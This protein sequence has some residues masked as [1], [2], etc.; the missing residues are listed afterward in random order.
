MDR[1]SLEKKIEAAL[2]KNSFNPVYIHVTVP[3]KGIAL[4]RGL[5]E[6]DDDLNRLRKVVDAVEGVREV[7]SEAS[8]RPAAFI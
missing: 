5:T 6:S 2:L 8:V 4:V 7:R 1:L 3:E